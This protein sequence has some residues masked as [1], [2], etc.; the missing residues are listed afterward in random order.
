[1]GGRFSLQKQVACFLLLV[2]GMDDQ[3]FSRPG[4]LPKLLPETCL[5]YS[6]TAA[7]Q[8]TAVMFGVMAR[9]GRGIRINAA[10]SAQ[11]AGSGDD[12]SPLL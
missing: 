5:V 12:S 10:S 7:A 6:I 1:M 2:G 9:L 4:E 3:R 8:L 11:G